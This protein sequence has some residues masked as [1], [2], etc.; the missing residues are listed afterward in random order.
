MGSYAI[1]AVRR[2]LPVEHREYQVCQQHGES[3]SLA[4]L[5]LSLSASSLADDY[6]GN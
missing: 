5:S 2:W 1:Q 6:L 3:I 4:R